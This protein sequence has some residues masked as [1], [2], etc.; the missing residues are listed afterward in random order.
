[1]GDT[2]PE[3]A[4]MKGMSHPGR[5]AELRWLGPTSRADTTEGLDHAWDAGGEYCTFQVV[6]SRTGRPGLAQRRPLD[7]RPVGP[8]L[9]HTGALTVVYL[10]PRHKG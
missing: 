9:L 8:T 10:S 2:A 6:Y 3:L 7:G 4:A 1:M 5:L